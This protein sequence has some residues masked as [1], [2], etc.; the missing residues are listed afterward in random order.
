[1]QFSQVRFN[2]LID[3]VLEGTIQRTCFQPWEVALLLDIEGCL[4]DYPKKRAL[5][6]RYQKAVL[7]H[8]E[9]G[10]QVPLKLSEYLER[11]RL[12]RQVREAGVAPT[13]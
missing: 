3:E 7:K 5:L 2:R 9:R 13:R 10:A 12:R 8:Y 6:R 11:L 1:M 4:L